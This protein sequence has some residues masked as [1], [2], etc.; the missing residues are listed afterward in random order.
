MSHVSGLFKKFP[1]F[2][3]WEAGGGGG[4][5]D[6]LPIMTYMGGS[7]QKDSSFLFPRD[8]ASP[9]KTVLSV[10]SPVAITIWR[11]RLRSFKIY[12]LQNIVVRRL[13]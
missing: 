13:G 4:G 10:P 11:H 9:F 5:W 12:L 6:G 7:A 2:I 8:E 1:Y 3:P